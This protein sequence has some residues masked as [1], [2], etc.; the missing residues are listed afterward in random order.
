LSIW[1]AGVRREASER[2]PTVGFSRGC[3]EPSEASGSQTGSRPP[4]RRGGTSPSS[5]TCSRL[6]SGCPQQGQF[7]LGLRAMSGVTRCGYP[8]RP[9]DAQRT[10]RALRVCV[11][12]ARR[13]RRRDRCRARPALHRVRLPSGLG[14]PPVAPTGQD[15]DRGFDGEH[16]APRG[17]HPLGMPR[18]W[19]GPLSCSGLVLSRLA[20]TLRPV[21]RARSP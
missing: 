21:H 3:P 6:W 18:G 1:S 17:S 9:R 12:A 13:R 15:R 16:D 7:V 4:T 11:T 10:D 14:L 19:S 5:L 8:A 2:P 20:R